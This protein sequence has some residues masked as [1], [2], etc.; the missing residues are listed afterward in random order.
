MAPIELN[1]LKDQLKDLLDKGFI[2]PSTSSWGAPMLFVRK[3]D[4]S[5]RICFDYKQLNK[6]TIKNKY[7]LQT[8]PSTRKQAISKRL[9]TAAG[10]RTD[11]VPSS[12]VGQSEF[13]G[14]EPSHTSSTPFPP[15]DIRRDPAPLV[16]PSGNIDHD[17]SSQV[18]LLTRL[19][20]AQ[21]PRRT[22]RPLL[23]SWEISNGPN[24][25]PVVWK[26]F[27]E[28]FL[29]HYL[30]VEIRRARVDKFLIF[31]QGNMS[32][33]EYSMHFDS[34]ASTIFVLTSL[35][36]VD[37]A[38][39]AAAMSST[40]K[41]PISKRLEIAAGVGTGQVP[42]SR[43]AQSEFQ[44]KEPS[45]TSSTLFPPEDTRRDPAPLVPPSGTTDHDMSSP[46][47]FLTRLVA[48]QVQRQNIGVADKRV[49]A[50]FCDIINLDPPVFTGSDPKEDPHTFIDQVHHTLRVMHASDIEVVE[51]A[52]YRLQDVAFFWYDSWEISNGP[53]SPPVVWKEFSEAFLHHNLPVEIRRARVNKFLILRQGNMSVREY[54]MQFDSLASWLEFLKDYDVEILY[55]PSKANVVTDV[56]SSKS[57]GSLVHIE[58][59]RQGLTK[60]LHQLANMR[61]RL[62]DSNDGGIIVQNTVV[63]ARQYED[64]TLV[65][66]RE[67]IQ[68]R[69]I[70]DFEIGGDR[71]LR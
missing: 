1:E 33:R 63:K 40:R 11:Q 27:S 18:Q 61:I 66:L 51:L 31:R 32:V 71:A 68:Q 13:Q 28:A 4:G 47:Q 37:A 45:H 19:V 70:T 5:L 38:C 29:H 39:R 25:P 16:P 15:E 69:K 46:V 49:S 9:K 26:E 2:R 22:H 53:N 60:E 20:A 30:L 43:V 67:G 23:I 57:M 24:S 55:H 56:L 21:T 10:V 50:R 65:R 62:L 64:P 12:R 6:V 35:L 3:K 58:A 59:G 41:Q 7:L 36:F 48:A 34:L 17:M 8:M 44:S 54:S 14:K 52:S 42:P